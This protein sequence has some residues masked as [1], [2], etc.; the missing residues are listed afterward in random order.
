MET[1]PKQ[2]ELAIVVE[3]PEQAGETRGWNGE[4]LPEPV[5]YTYLKGKSKPKGRQLELDLWGTEKPGEEVRRRWPWAEAEVW[6]DNML[7]ALE[8]GVKG[9]KWYSLIDKVSSYKNLKAAAGK[10]KK[11]GG[12]PGPDG[13]TVKRF[14]KHRKKNLRKLQ[15]EIRNR[16]YTP[17]EIRRKWIEKQGKKK[18]S[19]PLGIPNVRDRI[20]QTALRNVIE[21]I[22]EKEFSENSYG[23]R[24]GRGTKDAL[25][26]VKRLIKQ[27]YVWIIDADLKSYFDTIPYGKLMEMIRERISD[28]ETL[29]L[30]DQF[31][32]QKVVEKLKTW[33]PEKGVPQGAVISPLLSNIYLNPLDHMAEAKGRKMVRYAD[34]FIVL[35]KT[36][37]EAKQTLE[38]IKEWTEK[39]ELTLH[40]NKTKIANVEDGERVD[41]LG[42]F[43]YK[44]MQFPSK[45]SMKRFKM[46]MKP[47][48]KR[49]N[50]KS[51]KK[52]I[53]EINPIIVGWFEYFKHSKPNTFISVD[54]WI[55][56]RLR[57]ILR[58]RRN[59]RGR[60]RGKD[61]QTW[62]NAYF[63][64]RGLFSLHT[65][66][67]TVRR[68]LQM[69]TKV[70]L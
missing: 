26:E 62:P 14:M 2:L 31:L 70:K 56:G 12:A 36:E 38:E 19:R 4:K 64:D 30:I 68:S 41:F 35:C 18:E 43:F 52:I 60:A 22:F 65:A 53:E 6:T 44:N 17:G 61:H 50:G 32:K 46:K 8:K 40:P 24:P 13:V 39:M 29:K 34:D 21:P 63:A 48:T 49:T 37:T 59:K 11:N 69:N 58:K 57:S 54:G 9:G 25:R 7:A 42:Y 27:G 51:L 3:K 66:Y 23:F 10:V 55:R 20:V 67:R 16:T 15:R 47:L 45:K 5:D 33:S 1:K 28:G